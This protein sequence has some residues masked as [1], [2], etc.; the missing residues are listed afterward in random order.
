MWDCGKYH[1]GNKIIR[2]GGG[3]LNRLCLGIVLGGIVKRRYLKTWMERTWPWELRMCDLSIRNH[4]CKE[5]QVRMRWLIRRTMIGKLG[6]G[7]RVRGQSWSGPNHLQPYRPW[8]FWD[9]LLIHG[10]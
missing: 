9:C 5:S 7:N 6:E 8:E 10:Q 3:S 4:K 1:K 2:V